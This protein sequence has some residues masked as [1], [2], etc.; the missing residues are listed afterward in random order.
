[1]SSKLCCRRDGHPIASEPGP[2]LCP[3]RVCG[4]R[5]WPSYASVCVDK[6]H[7][8]NETIAALRK[9]L[10][11]SRVLSRV[12][13][14]ASELGDC[15]V[16]CLVEIAKIFVGPDPAAQFIPA[17]H[18]PRTFQQDLQQF[19]RLLLDSDSQT[20]FA[21]LARVERNLKGSESHDQGMPQ[22]FHIRASHGSLALWTGKSLVNLG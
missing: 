14:R 9:S 21:Q 5:I 2:R 17:D 8:R 10:Y 3:S 19:Q 18:Y 7:V 12:P 11:I 16:D 13:Q 1:M 6:R 20:C 4:H 22:G 15:N